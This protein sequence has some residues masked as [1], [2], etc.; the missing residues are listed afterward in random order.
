MLSVSKI[1]HADGS[2]YTHTTISGGCVAPYFERDGQWDGM[3]SDLLGLKGQMVHQKDLDALWQGRSNSTNDLLGSERSRVKNV[4]FDFTFSAP[5]SVSILFALAKDELSSIVVKS[6]EDAT[7]KAFSYL[8]HECSYVRKF[9]NGT[10]TM[11]HSKGLLSAQF[12]H[13]TSR[14]NDPHLHTHSTI[15][16]LSVTSDGKWSALAT[17]S[18]YAH[19]QNAGL[20]YHW[21]LRYDLS[22]NLGIVFTN[23]NPYADIIGLDRKVILAFSKRLGQ[24]EG[25]LSSLDSPSYKAREVALYQSRPSKDLSLSYAQLKDIWTDEALELGISTKKLHSL[26]HGPKHFMAIGNQSSRIVDSPVSQKHTG[27]NTLPA[28]NGIYDDKEKDNTSK[29]PSKDAATLTMARNFDKKS[30]SERYVGQRVKILS[31]FQITFTRKNLLTICLLNIDERLDLQDLEDQIDRLL[32]SEQIIT[33]PQ[34]DNGQNLGTHTSIIA[35]IK[36]DPDLG[37]DDQ[38]V[39][40]ISSHQL[41]ISEGKEENRPG[42]IENIDARVREIPYLKDLLS[43][44][45][46]KVYMHRDTLLLLSKIENLRKTGDEKSNCSQ[47]DQAGKENNLLLQNVSPKYIDPSGSQNIIFTS[48]RK[49]AQ[50]VTDITGNEAVSVDEILY[51]SKLQTE[52]VLGRLEILSRYIRT[53]SRPGLHKGLEAKVCLPDSE[54]KFEKLQIEFNEQVYSCINSI[55]SGK[56]VICE[57]SATSKP[58]LLKALLNNQKIS[59]KI[60]FAEKINLMTILPQKTTAQKDLPKKQSREYEL[61]LP[62]NQYVKLDKPLPVKENLITENFATTDI[63][64]RQDKIA[65]ISPDHTSSGNSLIGEPKR[66]VEILSQNDKVIVVEERENFF[67]ELTR[68][69]RKLQTLYTRVILAVDNSLDITALEHQLRKIYPITDLPDC[70]KYLFLKG[71]TSYH[72]FISRSTANKAD[73]KNSTGYLISQKEEWNFVTKSIIKGPLSLDNLLILTRD[74][75]KKTDLVAKASQSFPNNVLPS[76]QRHKSNNLRGKYGYE[77]LQN[78]KPACI[79]TIGFCPEVIINRE[80]SDRKTIIVKPKFMPAAELGKYIDDLSSRS[81]ELEQTLLSKNKKYFNYHESFL[82]IPHTTREYGNKL[83]PEEARADTTIGY[84]PA[85]RTDTKLSQGKGIDPRNPGKKILTGRENSDEISLPHQKIY[86]I[87]DY[88]LRI[89]PDL[90]R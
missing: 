71:N 32:A 21:A 34:N 1:H 26:V 16:N 86:D 52:K 44:R 22:N 13:R 28:T 62:T 19:I 85:H 7:K 61:D 80:I 64:H 89:S 65:P 73:T 41:S 48:S 77:D 46:H 35:D 72:H 54:R 38:T 8:E 56:D 49:R 57:L 17:R 75:L 45:P 90:S 33:L 2:Y 60:S 6:H 69:I 20:L 31:D 47:F 67:S 12:L 10:Q 42:N 63:K 9:E 18:L 88:R 68:H 66:S 11:V 27:N 55:A 15:A 76:D 4:A 84:L 74:Q 36:L 23:G 78:S 14:A 3:I 29:T 24:I 39:K 30:A 51:Q 53:D 43:K 25:M 79:L 50:L 37:I 58:I 81:Q 70:N 40:K 87:A 83:S 82:K 59:E 5:K